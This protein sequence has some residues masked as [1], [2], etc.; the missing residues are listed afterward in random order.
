MCC[1]QSGSRPFLIFCLVIV[2]LSSEY[3][4]IWPR[5]CAFVP[6]LTPDLMIPTVDGPS[7]PKNHLDK[8]SYP[9][10]LSL[11][12][13]GSTKLGSGQNQI[14]LFETG[15]PVHWVNV[16]PIRFWIL[17]LQADV[18]ISSLVVAGSRFLA[19]MVIIISFISLKFQ[20]HHNSIMPTDLPKSPLYS[21]TLSLKVGMDVPY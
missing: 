21:L 2:G 8:Q 9:F 13:L 19:Y 6:N 3:S 17:P 4:I 15:I 12:W 1:A 20:T 7:C 11:D 5:V 18:G 16:R 14:N 10:N